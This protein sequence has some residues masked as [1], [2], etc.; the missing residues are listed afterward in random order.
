MLSSQQSDTVR[1]QAVLLAS[2]W[3][4]PASKQSCLASNWPCPNS[5][6]CCLPSRWHCQTSMRYCSTNRWNCFKRS[7]VLS[8]Q[9]VL[10]SNQRC[11]TCIIQPAAYC[12]LASQLASGT[13]RLAGGTVQPAKWYCRASKMVLSSRQNGTLHSQGTLPVSRRSCTATEAVLPSQH[14][15]SV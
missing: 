11:G 2:N 13:V 4:C 10:L 1:P 9:Q 8:N 5:K 12:S 14:N 15:G 6:W 3:Y 7:V